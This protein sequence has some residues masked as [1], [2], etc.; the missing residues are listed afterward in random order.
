MLLALNT[1]FYNTKVK[2]HN[3]KDVHPTRVRIGQDGSRTLILGDIS[4]EV[5]EGERTIKNKSTNHVSEI[6]SKY[7]ILKYGDSDTQLVVALPMNLF[8][9]RGYRDLYKHKMLGVHSGIIDGQQKLV[10]VTKCTVFAEGAA[11]YLQYKSLFKDKLIGI[12][13][14]GGNTV[15]AMIYD[16]GELIRDSIT[17]LDLG[18]IKLE[19]EIRDALNIANSWNV[20]DYEVRDIL[21]NGEC[22]DITDRITKTHIDKIKNE[23]IE[24]KWNVDR[25]TIF[26]T[27]G[28][29]AQL[30]QQLKGCFNN[31]VVSDNGIFDNVDGLYRVG[32]EVMN[33]E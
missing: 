3:T 10:N 8:L 12:I 32:M 23:L 7:N 19:R 9:N 28:G 29:S 14:I 15:N 13:D 6:C 33:R 24:K 20:Q 2:T 11:A 26:A 1:G 21:E 31:V 16:R 18:M 30:K 5:A 17:T 27:G 4:Y 25:L 22:R